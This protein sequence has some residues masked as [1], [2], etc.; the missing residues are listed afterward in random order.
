[1]PYTH[2]HERSLSLRST[3]TSVKSDSAKLVYSF[4]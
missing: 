4:R 3:G 1:M 2:I